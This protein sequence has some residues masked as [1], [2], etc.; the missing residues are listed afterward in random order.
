MK[1]PT[2]S[3]QLEMTCSH[4]KCEKKNP[5]WHSF[6]HLKSDVGWRCHNCGTFYR[7]MSYFDYNQLLKQK[8]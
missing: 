3:E 7:N 4:S 5:T 2:L 6:I 8:P 1:L